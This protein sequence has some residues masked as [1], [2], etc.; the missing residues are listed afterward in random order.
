MGDPVKN[1]IGRRL[2]LLIGLLPA[3]C[4]AGAIETVDL[5]SSTAWTISVDGGA[6]RSIIVP[7]RGYNAQGISASDNVLYQRSITIPAS[8]AGKTVK[9]QFG[10]VNYGADVSIDNTLITSHRNLFIPFEADLTGKVTAGSAYTLK[11]KA[12]TSGHYQDRIPRGTPGWCNVPFG[13]TRYIRLVVL[14]QVYIK[15]YWIK[16]SVTNDRLTAD[17][18]IHNT[19]AQAK[20][21]TLGASLT[22]WNNVQWAYPSIAS[23]TVV[24]PANGVAQA[25][26]STAW[27]LGPESYWWPNMPFNESYQAKLHFLNLNIKEGATTLDT[28]M[29]RFGFVEYGEQLYYYTVNGVRM[30][31]PSDGTAEGQFSYDAYTES[32]AFKPPTGPGT[33]CPESFKRYMRLGYNTNRTHASIPTEYM[34]GVADE[35]GFML[36]PES[37][38][39]GFGES[40]V[41]DSASY[42][43]D[44]REMVIT[45]R[46]HPSIC[47]Y[48]VHNE[49]ADA[50][51]ERLL[52]DAGWYGDSTKP[53]V[54]EGGPNNMV[55]R[56]E[57]RHTKGHAYNMLHYAN[58]RN[59]QPRRSIAGMGE[60]AWN[61][62]G[63]PNDPTYCGNGGLM[64]QAD[65]GL[66]MR[67]RDW[68][69]FAAW[70][71]L[72]FWPN[73]L[74]GVSLSTY[75]C[76]TQEASGWTTAADRTD[77]VNGWGSYEIQFLQRCL[78]PFIVCDS[79]I[80]AA[81]ACYSNPWPATIPALT[82]GATTNRK[83]YLF[84]G[85]L[86]GNSM[87]L[88]WELRWGSATGTLAATGSVDTTIEPGFY[89]T[90]PVSFTVPASTATAPPIT[91]S[92]GTEMYKETRYYFNVSGSNLYFILRSFLLPPL[93]R[94]AVQPGALELS[95]QGS[96]VVNMAVTFAEGTLP[97]LSVQS[98]AGWLTSAINGQGNSQT[99]QVTATTTGLASGN[100]AASLVLSAAGY[101]PVSCPVKLQV[102]GTA[103]P[104]QV[105][106]S[107]SH[108]AVLPNGT[109]GF[110]ARAIDQYGNPIAA[111]LTWGVSG[112]G[113][114]DANGLFTS[115][116]AEG[117]FL[118]K[119]RVT[120]DTT[121]SSLARVV[122]TQGK[123][124]PTGNITE[125]LTLNNA[126]NYTSV[127]TAG[128]IDK[129]ESFLFSP[130]ALLPCHGQQ[131]AAD[132]QIFTWRTRAS[133]ANGI[134]F[135]ST[136][137]LYSAAYG[138][139]TLLCPN[140]RTVRLSTQ[141]MYNLDVWRNGQ[142]VAA[143]TG[144]A[145]VPNQP[146][147]VT[148]FALEKGSN[149]IVFK[150]SAV[151]SPIAAM[152]FSDQSGAA[153]VD[154][155]YVIDTC[156]GETPAVASPAGAAF[157]KPDLLTLRVSRNTV[158][159]AVSGSGAYRIALVTP[160]GRVIK[161]M[162]G[163]GSRT[164]R[165]PVRGMGAGVYFVK[166]QIGMKRSVSRIAIWQ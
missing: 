24:V 147:D 164:W 71:T 163:M 65:I 81:N 162:Q 101:E 82:A 61:I 43:D 95:G 155:R 160:E 88:V 156:G 28:I 23:K 41:W 105:I 158:D 113:T 157:A 136:T 39:R 52:I 139:I 115:T 46:N 89:K 8:A 22:S 25:T 144:V 87:K 104:A 153:L 123:P 130:D 15:D 140:A 29:P 27:G 51:A 109:T 59:F 103:A 56:K 148:S 120:G 132:G 86:R 117:A 94:F 72:S 111:P 38:I 17:V 137:Q 79:A 91:V 102:T 5:A 97:A 152:Q 138:S 108:A 7:G 44:V 33:G 96:V 133:S 42:C 85:G 69:Y 159:F 135:Q 34:M 92:S 165:V 119:A 75:K 131:I 20:T 45:C 40:G 166:A 67:K 84:N 116:G 142:M 76:C 146:L 13:I 93:A 30:T 98:S 122:V 58:P 60:Y 106:I 63:V 143:L 77:N 37:A 2:C 4:L 128:P 126:Q 21:L 35:V 99:I 112:G 9:I 121:K 127:P 26:L 1:A 134:W 70:N 129:V 12:Y 14:P 66:D 100:L 47:R 11:V 107:P 48:S 49:Y 31:Q 150:L 125:M 3:F 50:Q 55:E 141:H 10:A 145:V 90:V 73:L 118:I 110:A 57:G 54:T 32:P 83:V 19:S 149:L 114:I 151:T 68:S 78:N 62:G 16:P 80:D 154:V 74:P 18:T 53:L 161:T 36:Y 64:R 6:T 124:L